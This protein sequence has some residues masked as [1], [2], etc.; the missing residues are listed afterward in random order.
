M[1]KEIVSIQVEEL[2]QWI[3][4]EEGEHM[5]DHVLS[6]KIEQLIEVTKIELE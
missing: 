2:E 5:H 3:D 1:T 6:Y 4:E